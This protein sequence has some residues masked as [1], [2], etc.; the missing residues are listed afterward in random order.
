MLQTAFEPAA[1]LLAIQ[2][3]ALS[4]AHPPHR[5]PAFVATVTS[6]AAAS[7]PARLITPRPIAKI[8]GI[9]SAA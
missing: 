3:F 2:V 5:L 4:V 9:F 6:L 7:I 1:F 8:R